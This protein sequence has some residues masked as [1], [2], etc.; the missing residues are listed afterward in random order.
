MVSA[1]RQQRIIIIQKV[2]VN[3]APDSGVGRRVVRWLL[4]DFQL[5]QNIKN[6][7]L[8]KV[9]KGKSVIFGFADI[10]ELMIEGEEIRQEASF[11][12]LGVSQDQNTFCFVHLD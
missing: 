2:T 10:F 6:K 9:L 3:T 12:R 1:Y 11:A 4:V 8:L 7:G 5:L